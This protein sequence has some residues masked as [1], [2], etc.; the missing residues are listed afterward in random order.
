[1]YVAINYIDRRVLWDALISFTASYDQ[2]WMVIGDFNVIMGT[3]EKAGG[4]S[5]PT[6]SCLDFSNM[7]DACCLTH[8]SIEGISLLGVIVQTRVRLKK[9]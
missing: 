6:I 4:N 2:P 9:D 1:M 8:L 7:I 3:H 5:P